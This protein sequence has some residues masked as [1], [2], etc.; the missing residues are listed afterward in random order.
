MKVKEW[1]SYNDARNYTDSIGGMGG[2]FSN[3]MRWSNYIERIADDYK[4]YYEAVRADVIEK[5][6]R[7][8]GDRHQYGDAGVPLFEDDTVGTFSYR[9]WGD[10]MA[11]IW[12][13]HEN[14]DYSYMDFYC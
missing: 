14:K 9:A 11:A 5:K 4:P 2:F 1:I 13:E 8:T 3:G 6:I 10:L 7:L 12:S